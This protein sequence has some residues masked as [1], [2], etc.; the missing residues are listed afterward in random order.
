VADRLKDNIR[1]LGLGSGGPKTISLEQ[2][3][4]CR[5]SFKNDGSMGRF[6]LVKL[7]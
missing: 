3:E 2:P 4:I 7:W 5:P 1:R 6:P